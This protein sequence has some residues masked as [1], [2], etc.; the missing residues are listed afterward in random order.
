MKQLLN[1]KYIY[2]NNSI[3]FKSF[4]C[5]CLTLINIK[6]SIKY[7]FSKITTMFQITVIIIS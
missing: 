4:L 2:V 6:Y 3:G 1:L 5:K 7:F